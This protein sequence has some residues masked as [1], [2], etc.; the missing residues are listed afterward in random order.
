MKK[1]SSF[2]SLVLRHKP[3]TLGI[4]FNDCN[5]MSINGWIDIPRL[6]QG[7]KENGRVVTEIEIADIVKA[8]EKGRY[9]IE[10]NKIRAVQGHSLPVE[11]GLIQKT[12]PTFLYHGTAD[13]FVD[14]IL[15][16]GLKP[17]GRQFVH[18]SE[19]IET[20]VNV[21]KRHGKPVV[22][23]IDCSVSQPFFQAE[24]G[25][26]L[27]SH[28]KTEYISVEISVPSKLPNNENRV[29]YSM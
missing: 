1:I 16:E 20:A 5:G 21:G 11:L 6:I 27:T 24:N 14:S 3:E 10:N 28:I 13:R 19:D 8:D 12:P 26:W 22:L 4:K 7:F 23:T 17:N 2:L 18:L 29:K 15:K 25:V 9:S